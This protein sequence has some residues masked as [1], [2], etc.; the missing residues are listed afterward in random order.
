MVPSLVLYDELL[1]RYEYFCM[2]IPILLSRIMGCHGNY[3]IPYNKNAFLS[4]I[5]FCIKVVQ[6][7][8]FTPIVKLPMCP[9]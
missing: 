7:K 5:F 3:E 2:Y 1:L 9:I 6:F 4:T 8:T